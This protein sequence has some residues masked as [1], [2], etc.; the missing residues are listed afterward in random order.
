MHQPRV[1]PN[2]KRYRKYLKYLIINHQY[3]INHI[4]FGLGTALHAR[5]LHGM[6]IIGNPP[7]A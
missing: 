7:A 1:A 5:H 6:S 4:V 3:L 2:R